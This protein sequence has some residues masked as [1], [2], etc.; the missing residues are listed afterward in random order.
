MRCHM[1]RNTLKAWCGYVTIPNSYPMDYQK[2]SIDYPDLSPI[3]T[4][5]SIQVHGGVTY[6]SEQENGDIIIGFDCAHSGD[7]CPGFYA[8]GDH[9]TSKS[10]VYRTKEYVI[11][12]TESMV[13]QILEIPTIKRHTKIIN[14]LRS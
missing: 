8:Y 4:Y 14:I 5:L 11:R 1:K 3:S 10:D 12:E 6:E 9:Y 2:E 7:L 13:D